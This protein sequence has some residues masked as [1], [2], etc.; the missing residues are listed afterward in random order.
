[1]L[2]F[3]KKIYL[4]LL[5]LG[6]RLWTNINWVKYWSKTY[7]FLW[8]RKKI[9]SLTSYSTKDG[10]RRLALFLS[11][12]VYSTDGIKELFDV[13]PYPKVTEYKFKNG[14]PIGDCG[15]FAYYA[16]QATNSSIM[17]VFW[18][19]SPHSIATNAHNVALMA[20]SDK[21]S[22]I[23]YGSPV[24]TL[25]SDLNI[26]AQ[27]IAQRFDKDAVVLSWS[28]RDLELNVIKRSK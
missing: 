15:A 5:T 23:D 22:F 20:E 2:N 27:H 13:F 18:R 8:N 6:I 26:V 4:L 24:T 7:H 28:V 10:M 19:K 21:F 12:A 9:E 25:S 17:T 11:A 3:Y 1:M 14:L 16:A